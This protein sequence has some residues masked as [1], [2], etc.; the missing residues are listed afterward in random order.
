EFLA[1]THFRLPTEAEWEYASRGGFST[2]MPEGEVDNFAF[3]KRNSMGVTH[4]V[5]QLNPNGFGLYDMFGNVAELCAEVYSPA[6]RSDCDPEVIDPVGQTFNW[7]VL[8]DKHEVR[9]GSYRDDPS[10]CKPSSRL[11]KYQVYG[12]IDLG[13]RVARSP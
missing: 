11:D 4:P 3:T 6:L 5:G 13:F 1:R 8:S 7:F 2:G 10:D 12:A 9:G